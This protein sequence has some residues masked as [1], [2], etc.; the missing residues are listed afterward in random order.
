MDY[1]PLV[2]PRLPKPAPAKH[3]ADSRYWRSFKSPV[4]V[5]E[6][7]PVTSIHFALSKPHRY[8]VTAATRVHIYAPRT[9]KIAKT[10]ARFKDVAR[11]GH[12]R[13]D[14]KL[15][16]AGDDSGLIQIF[17]VNSRAI[18]RTLDAHK[19]PVHVTKFSALDHTQ[20]LSCS[21]DTTVR[22]W[23]VPSQASITTFTAHTDYVR[24]GQ[25]SPADPH[26]VLTGSYDGTVRLFDARTGACELR[27]GVPGSTPAGAGA[28]TPVEQVLMFPSGTAALSAAGSILRVWDLV[29][30]GRCLRALSN[31]QKT[32]TALA[33]NTGASRLLTGGLDHMVKVYDAATYSVVHTMRYSAPV[34]CLALSP[35]ETHLAVGMSDGTLSVRRRTPKASE[36]APS[37][38]PF[39][40]AAL[41]AGTFE[42]FL[43]GTLPAI[44]Q[45]RVKDR[46]RAKPRGDADEFKVESKRKRRLREYDRLLKGFK[47]SAAL[48]SALRKQVPP[49]TA[50]ALIRELV[51]RDGLRTALAGRD[52]VLLEPILRLLLKYVADPR[53]G[54]LV[55][56]VSTLVL[57]MYTPVLGQSP[58]IDALVLRLRRKVDAE[59]QVQK[60]LAKVKGALDMLFAFAALSA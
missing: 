56:E 24:A 41:R 20:V 32:V 5:K 10:V 15:L 40:A 37:S 47:Y 49:A 4:F 30:G 29:A 23:D 3:S 53:F 39:S 44:G 54:E 60:D 12:I 27:M 13:A 31:H 21:D 58:T 17:D 45:P 9:Q 52:D 1:Q 42:S 36:G 18:L 57:D 50:F 33:F 38:D 22:L 6:Y 2:V 16:V 14:G 19:Q 25:V 46:T 59:L 48:D 8:A 51:Y 11:S 7:A 35:D 43:G 26:L 55:C 28:G 34:M